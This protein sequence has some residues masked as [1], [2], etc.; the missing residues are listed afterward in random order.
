M[1]LDLPRRPTKNM[2]RELSKVTWVFGA[3]FTGFAGNWGW[4]SL[5]SRFPLG[6]LSNGCLPTNLWTWLCDK[7]CPETFQILL[8]FGILLIIWLWHRRRREPPANGTV[9]WGDHVGIDEVLWAQE[10]EQQ[11][12]CQERVLCVR[13]GIYV[14]GNIVVE[15]VSVFSI[16]PLLNMF[17]KFWEMSFGSGI[18]GL[19][20]ILV[21]ERCSIKNIHLGLNST[22][23]CITWYP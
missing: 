12:N 13:K 14:V 7:P 1:A 3:G 22:D 23:V 5:R 11:R 9:R 18:F 21:L 6:F 20:T 2:S 4:G 16:D 10:R 19:N 17:E 8:H 15:Y